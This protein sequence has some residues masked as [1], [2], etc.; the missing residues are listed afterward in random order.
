MKGANSASSKSL[1]GVNKKNSKVTKQSKKDVENEEIAMY[2]SKLKQLVPFM[3]RNRRLSKLQVIQ[4]VI[5]YIMDLQSALDM[6]PAIDVMAVRSAAAAMLS[7]SAQQNSSSNATPPTRKPLGVL[8]PNAN[9]GNDTSL[10][11]APPSP[12]SPSPSP[13]FQDSTF[14][15]SRSEPDLTRYFLV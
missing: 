2:L 9:M 6:H 8:P 10:T 14:I 3:P 12:P 4:Y 7:N 13:P 5:E 1:V 15:R 11:Q